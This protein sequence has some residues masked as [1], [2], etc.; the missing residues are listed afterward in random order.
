MEVEKNEAQSAS[1]NQ[2]EI[3]SSSSSSS[4]STSGSL[5]LKAVKQEFTLSPG[6]YA[7]MAIRELTKRGTSPESY[8]AGTGAGA[9]VVTGSKGRDREEDV[10]ELAGAKRTK[11]E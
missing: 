8:G 10:G 5:S 2:T 4:T 11:I 6:C 1:A 3:A 9:G 7:T